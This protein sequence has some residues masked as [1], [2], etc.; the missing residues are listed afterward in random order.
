[1]NG[2]RTKKAY[3]ERVQKHLLNQQKAFAIILGQCMQRL[4]DKMHD[5]D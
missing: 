5:N 4:K 3:G 2:K 1:V